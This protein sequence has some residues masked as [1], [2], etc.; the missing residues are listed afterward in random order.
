MPVFGDA[1]HAALH[2]PGGRGRQRAAHELRAA[3]DG[4]ARAAQQLGQRDLAVAG[5]A[6]DGGD[7]ARAQRERHLAQA[8]LPTVF[9]RCGA[10]VV[11]H[12][13][14]VAHRFRGPALRRLDRVADHPQ[15]ELR[16]RGVGR[17][18]L[19]D[20]L[21]AAQHR[22]AL[23]HAQHLAE[24]V[25]DEDDRQALRHHLRERGE[26]RLALLRREHGRGLVEDQD[27]RAAVQRL[28]DFH[29]LALA[30]REAADGR[31]GLH[32]QAEALGDLEQPRT[33]RGAARDRAP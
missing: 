12:A 30:D 13:H 9:G 6:R 19:G 4:A 17:A 2:Q 8:V 1:R 16:L 14:R 18:C 33:G 21:A 10:H 25:A 15:R 3:G 26:E 5:D 20:Q 7:L 27:A 23:R 32:R 24:L 22:D 28:E 31:V 29:A 11:E